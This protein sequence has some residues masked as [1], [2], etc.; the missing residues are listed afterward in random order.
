MST[1]KPYYFWGSLQC[2]DYHCEEILKIIHGN[3]FLN[4][5]KEKLFDVPILWII[6]YLKQT[7]TENSQF[8]EKG[9]DYMYGKSLYFDIAEH[10]SIDWDTT[11]YYVINADQTELF[12]SYILDEEK[13]VNDIL[14]ELKKQWKAI[15]NKIDNRYYS[16]KFQ[17][18]K[19]FD[20][21][22]QYAL[23][24][25]KPD[26]IFEGDVLSLLRNYN[27]SNGIVE[28]IWSNVFEIPY[29]LAKIV[30]LRQDD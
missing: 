11:Q 2:K 6:T 3:N 16:V 29:V 23:Q 26:Y 25:S 20:K 13:K 18:Y 7:V 19:H 4:S 10:I 12:E 15:F 28:F 9:A 1:F 8:F 24:L 17:N 22:R 14:S 27:Y 21:F 30:G 5:S